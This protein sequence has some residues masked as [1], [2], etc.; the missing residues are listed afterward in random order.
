M[1]ITCLAIDA[2][3][4]SPAYT[5]Q[6]FRQAM[7]A[8]VYNTTNR[9]VGSTGGTILGRQATISSTTVTWTCGAFVAIV[10]PDFTSTQ[11]SYFVSSDAAVTGAL[12][13]PNATNPRY[14]IIY[15][16]VNDTAIDSSGSRNATVSYL[17]GTAAPSPTIPAT[18]ARSLLLGWLLVPASGGG[19][20][21]GTQTNL[22]TCAVG[23]LLPVSSA[24]VRDA[25]FAAP[26]EGMWVDDLN[27]GGAY[28]YSGSAWQPETNLFAT[29]TGTP[30]SGTFDATKPIRRLYRRQSGTSDGGG[31]IPVTLANTC[32]L[33]V[34]L[35]LELGASG[36]LGTL[37]L[38]NGVTETTSA[39]VVVQ[40]RNL[41]GT[42]AAMP[43]TAYVISGTIDYQ[44]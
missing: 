36:S 34:N 8:L 32:V 2:S 16:Q 37:I 38:R 25:L 21:A 40:M 29:S 10:D 4:G 24:A 30:I 35:T 31:L 12:T 14:D 11:G 5:G 15:V 23:G 33:A 7:S 18:P 17:A 13:A 6:Q 22:Y 3:A 42:G 20:P 39:Q 9:A 28:R 43:T 1:T 44:V 41:T 27:V 19:S 26:V